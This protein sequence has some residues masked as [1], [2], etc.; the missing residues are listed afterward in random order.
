MKNKSLF[1]AN[2]KM[3]K[4][5]EETKSFFKDFLN[6]ISKEEESN[7]IFFPPAFSFFQAR[8]SLKDTKIALGAQN[9]HWERSGA[10]TGENSPQVAKEMGAKYTLVGHSE[11][12]M[13]FGLTDA[14]VAKTLRHVQMSDIIPILCVGELDIQK[15]R[16]VTTEVI[17]AQLKEG[18]SY[19]DFKRDFIVAYEP[20]WAIGTSQAATPEDVEEVHTSIKHILGDILKDT[21]KVQNVPLLYGGSVKIS[22]VKAL[23]KKEHVDGFLVGGASLNP[24]TFYSV[25]K[26]ATS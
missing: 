9:V 6:C 23:Y 22:N 24:D 11:R 10:F 1:I 15:E 2:W 7:F 5:P 17:A 21:Q 16:N 8:E 25:F 13:V 20:V 4:G 14:E 12:R 18:L 19:L 3:H 26:E